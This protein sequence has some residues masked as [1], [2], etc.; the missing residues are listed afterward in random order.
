MGPLGPL[1]PGPGTLGTRAWDPWDQGPGT[2]GTRAQVPGPLDRAQGP[3]PMV[4]SFE[5]TPRKSLPAS[6][7]KNETEHYTLRVSVVE[8]NTVDNVSEDE[9]SNA[10][11]RP[12]A[13]LDKTSKLCSACSAL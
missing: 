1:G 8:S 9:D 13:V 11:V 7:K 3:G 5:H 4:F 2:L 10:I 6:F 12:L